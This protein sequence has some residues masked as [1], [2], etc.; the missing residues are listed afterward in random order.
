MR[1]SRVTPQMLQIPSELSLVTWPLQRFPPVK[2]KK[3]T[4]NP[5]L[6][7]RPR[8]A[9]T[10]R[11]TSLV[12]YADLPGEFCQFRF[13]NFDHSPLFSRPSW[14]LSL[15]YSLK[16]SVLFILPVRVGEQ[17]AAQVTEPCTPSA[18]G[19]GLAAATV[20]SVGF[21]MRDLGGNVR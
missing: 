10:C 5:L 11:P 20:F 6:P 16:A 12:P 9:H 17:G 21:F 8:Q 3:D 1:Y 18:G 7:Y 15:D 2:K 19:P 13:Q 14:D 4:K